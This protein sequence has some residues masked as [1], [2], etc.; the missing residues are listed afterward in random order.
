[1]ASGKD[2]S[3]RLPTGSSALG[4]AGPLS[5]YSRAPV[6]LARMTACGDG[7]RMAAGCGRRLP[8]TLRLLGAQPRQLIGDDCA[9]CSA[10][11]SC[12]LFFLGLAAGGSTDAPCNQATTAVPARLQLQSE[13]TATE[14]VLQHA[15]QQ[16]PALISAPLVHLS[17]GRSLRKVAS[18]AAS[19]ATILRQPARVMWC[20]E[21]LQNVH[22]LQLN[23]ISAVDMHA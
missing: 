9:E 4:V 8:L 6:S 7:P 3:G 11:A 16:Q 18:V 21:A 5:G 19:H 13:I 10:N 20:N 2:S 22:G 17:L 12:W 15:N 14:M 23:F 1:M